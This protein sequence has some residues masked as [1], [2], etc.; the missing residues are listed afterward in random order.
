MR[1][2]EETITAV[3]EGRFRRE[4]GWSKAELWRAF[5]ALNR[6]KCVLYMAK[7]MTSAERGEQETLKYIKA[8]WAEGAQDAEEAL[9]WEA[10]DIVYMAALPW[11]TKKY[12]GE[13]KNGL[14]MRLQQHLRDG[15]G[16]RDKKEQRVHAE[17]RRL[18]AHRFVWFPIACWTGRGGQ[19]TEAMR[20]MI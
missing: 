16:S 3:Q 13:T 20:T 9:R 10:V 5:Y 8:A 1:G 4:R 2:G 12:V 11:S 19:V 17:L 14:E 18:G 15:Q 7:L 6:V